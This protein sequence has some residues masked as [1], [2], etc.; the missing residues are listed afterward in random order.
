MVA[1]MAS[2]DPEGWSYFERTARHAGNDYDIHL[3]SN[4]NGVGNLEVNAIQRASSVLLQKSLREG[5]GLTVTE[6]LWKFKPVVAGNVGG[7]PTQIIDGENGYLVNSIEETADRVTEILESTDMATKLGQA[8]HE[9]VRRNF[10]TT[11]NLKRYLELM[12]TFRTHS[13]PES[14]NGA[15]K[16]HAD[17]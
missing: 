16:S 17:D 1:S 6:G 14:C 10:L 4:L 2:D 11:T 12:H 9:H 3:L 7:I 15:I 5:F 8:G 13:R